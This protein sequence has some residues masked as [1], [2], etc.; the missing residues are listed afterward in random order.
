M[1]GL[2]LAGWLAVVRKHRNFCLTVLLSFVCMHASLALNK[3]GM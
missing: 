3:H 2:W 1:R